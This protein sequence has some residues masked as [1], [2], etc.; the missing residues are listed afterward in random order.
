M[1]NISFMK[2]FLIVLLVSISFAAGLSAFTSGIS[3]GNNDLRGAW[4]RVGDRLRIEVKDG[5]DERMQSFIT[6]EG[7][8]DFPCDVSD[9]AIYRDIHK[10][11]KNLWRCEF[12]VVTIGSCSTDYEEGI[13]RLTES[14]R[15]EITCPGYDKRIY[16]RSI[17]RYESE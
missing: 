15:M 8:E 5:T 4:V 1:V 13:I 3:D 12:L 16:E 17:P 6:L 10:V 14:N 9:L 11:G 7:N 2:R